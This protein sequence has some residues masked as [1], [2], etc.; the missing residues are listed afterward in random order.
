M[1]QELGIKTKHLRC[2]IPQLVNAKPW[3]SWAEGEDYLSGD[4]IATVPGVL[5]PKYVWSH[6][7]QISQHVGS[8]DTPLPPPITSLSCNQATISLMMPGFL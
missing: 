1:C 2:I 3:M 6:G 5:C 7:P 8:R 4:K